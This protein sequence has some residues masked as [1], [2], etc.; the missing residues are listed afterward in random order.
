MIR[1]N[2]IPVKERKKVYLEKSK[3]KSIL[4][5]NIML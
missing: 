2:E 4:V 1:W 3:G 5:K